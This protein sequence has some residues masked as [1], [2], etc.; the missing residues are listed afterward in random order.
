MAGAA[1]SDRTRL[2]AF[3]ATALEGQRT[4]VGQYVEQ[5]LGALV[6]R[7]DG[8]R[9]VLLASR[10]LNG[11]VQAGT[12][13]QAGPRLPNRTL[14]MQLAVP[15]VLARLKPALCHFTNS[16]GPLA[17]PCPL[18]LTLHDM[19]LFLHPET[20]PRR[21]LL[22]VRTLIP[23]AARRADA[24]IT[25][26]HSARR[27]IVR[28]LGVA[29]EK[30]HVIYEAAAPC[31]RQFD[32]GVPADA[33]ELARVRARYGLAGDELLYVGTLEP[34][35]N[36]ATLVRAFAALHRRG[37]A[38]RLLLVG[39]L[40]W[41][42]AGLLREIEALGL[43]ADVQLPGYVPEA[44]LPALYNLARAL[45]FP[46]IYEGFGLPVVEAM[47]C[48]LPVVTSDRSSL[49]E[50]GRG[51]ALLIDPGDSDALA[52]AIDR[53]LHDDELHAALRAAGPRRAAEFSWARAA[54]ETAAVYAAVTA[55]GRS[56]RNHR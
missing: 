29:P 47:A 20:Q 2:V 11:R 7:D 41:K 12:L 48:G 32:P 6:A 43:G 56:R 39:Q 30:V 19:S 5:L 22:A 10:E 23:A 52:A 4:G 44:D 34:R 37:R 55:A 33:A 9:Y 45:V 13:G 49:A 31:F 36:L 15:L 40:G 50:L 27:D 14:W 16:I 18:V 53:V 35:K 24:L 17:S 54:E 21:S 8:R 25:V 46:S 1:L 42:V 38:R 51:A 28:V 26:S 3:D